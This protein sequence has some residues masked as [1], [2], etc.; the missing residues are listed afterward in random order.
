[1]AKNTVVEKFLHCGWV[2]I[3][4]PKSGFSLFSAVR[5]S[6]SGQ[7]N[8]RYYMLLK[9]NGLYYYKSDKMSDLKGFVQVGD[10]RSVSHAPGADLPNSFDLH[11]AGKAL[12]LT[13]ETQIDK[14][15]W[16]KALDSIIPR[17]LGNKRLSLQLSC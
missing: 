15:Q 17:Q 13:A 8:K 1:M 12:R 16:L 2:Q 10:C 5:S 3:C 14:L 11:T 7:K 6:F 4:S 9:S